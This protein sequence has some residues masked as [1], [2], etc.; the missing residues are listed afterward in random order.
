MTEREILHQKRIFINKLHEELQPYLWNNRLITPEYY[1]KE[2]NAVTLK[3]QFYSEN[4]LLKGCVEWKNVKSQAEQIC[5][6]GYAAK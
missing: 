1:T 3:F 5:L 2:M 4:E 6:Y